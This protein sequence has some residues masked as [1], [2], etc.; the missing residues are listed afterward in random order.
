MK[1]NHIQNEI[2][3]EMSGLDD[4]MDKYEYL[5]N[6]GRNFSPP[7]GKFKTD[8]NALK[9]CQSKVWINAEL[10]GNKISFLADSDS[11]IT[12]GILALLLRVLNHQ[13]PED[14]ANSDLYFIDQIG[15]ST[16]LSPSRADGLASIIKQFKHFGAKFTPTEKEK[17]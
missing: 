14:I 6:L 5:I 17:S 10:K 13:H 8:E 2:I 7:E 11:L 9:G 3:Q 1:I 4:W 16:N 12:R 15:L